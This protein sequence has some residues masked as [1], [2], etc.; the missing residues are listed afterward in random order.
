[1]N[2]ISK[3][4]AT[5]AA[6]MFGVLSGSAMLLFKRVNNLEKDNIQLTNCM[7]ILDHRLNRCENAEIEIAPPRQSLFNP[8]V[9][10][11]EYESE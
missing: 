5:L 1:M 3:V 8:I 6:T 10:N 7:L 9:A 4:L 11:K 2:T